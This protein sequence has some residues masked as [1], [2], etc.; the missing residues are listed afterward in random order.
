MTRSRFDVLAVA[1]D[2]ISALAP[3]IEAVVRRDRD[4]AQQMR[5]SASSIPLNISEGN[6][7]LGADR[8]QHFR[9]AAG[10]AA[11]TRTALDVACAWGY[12]DA[13]TLETARELLDRVIAM[14]WRL[15]SPRG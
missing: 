6:R 15:A 4:L 11:E 10:S 8:S 7:R 12:V 5:R 13:A 9:I 2:L 3:A 14:L 1:L